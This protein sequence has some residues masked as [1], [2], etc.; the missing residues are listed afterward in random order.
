MG[1]RISERIF[2]YFNR[3]IKANETVKIKRWEAF[4]YK[5]VKQILSDNDRWYVK[6]KR[7]SDTYYIGKVDEK[8]YCYRQ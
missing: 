6:Y 1:W 5:I 2:T 3:K 8:N 7:D 4:I